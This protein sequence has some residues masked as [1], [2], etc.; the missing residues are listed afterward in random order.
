MPS[1]PRYALAPAILFALQT[2]PV[3]VVPDSNGWY[4]IAVGAEAGSYLEQRLSCAG[5][6]LDEERVRLRSVGGELEVWLAPQVRIAGHAGQVWANPEGG[7]RI[8][9][10][11]EGFFG[12]ALIAYEGSNL[13]IGG[14]I[15]SVPVGSPHYDPSAAVPL[16][17][18]RLGRLDKLSARVE[19]GGPA[20]PGAP[21]DLLRIG[22]GSGQ[23]WLRK[24]SWEVYF[25]RA[26]FPFQGGGGIVGARAAGPASRAF[27]V[28]IAGAWRGPI[29]G[30]VGVFG[31]VHLGKRGR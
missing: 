31:R 14:G 26:D 10:G 17:Y 30:N 3:A 2:A 22:L 21:P 25:G 11:Y 4:R 9:P 24:P 5:E 23:G 7:G 1:I 8:A 20:A 16:G 19:I 6:V 27:D 13:G 12:G 29:G 15:A 28:G 18:L